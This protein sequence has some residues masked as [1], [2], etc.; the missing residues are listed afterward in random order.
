[1]QADLQN[2]PIPAISTHNNI[3]AIYYTNNLVQLP[4]KTKVECGEKPHELT[5]LVSTVKAIETCV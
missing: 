4:D 5:S 2:V 1:M 3:H